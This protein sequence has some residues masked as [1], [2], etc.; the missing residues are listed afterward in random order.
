VECE[1]I[2]RPMEIALSPSKE[3]IARAEVN[4]GALLVKRNPLQVWMSEGVQKVIQRIWI[5][6]HNSPYS[7]RSLSGP[8]GRFGRLPNESISGQSSRE[9]NRIANR[10]AMNETSARGTLSQFSSLD[11]AL[12]W[13]GSRRL[14]TRDHSPR[15]IQS[16][17]RARSFERIFC[18]SEDSCASPDVPAN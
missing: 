6:F 1:K 14:E 9:N 17:I 5:H 11:L 18:Q 15:P 3:G 7:T 12:P 8:K 2:T 10:S 16:H 4:A 13:F